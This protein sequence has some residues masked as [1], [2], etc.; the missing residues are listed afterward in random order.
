MSFKYDK[1][2]YETDAAYLESLEQKVH[3]PDWFKDYYTAI[4][5]HSQPESRI[6]D[7]GCGTGITTAWLHQKRPNI[8]GVD[9]SSAFIEK[10]RSRGNYF[11][12]MD[13]MRLEYPDSHFDLVCS[14]DALEHVPGLSQA[15]SEMLRV[16]KPGGVMVVQTPN[17][18]TSVISTNYHVTLPNVFRKLR[19]CG[20]D[21]LHPKLRTV[22]QYALDVKFGDQDAYNLI[23]PLWLKSHLR[24]QSCEIL[25]LTTFALYFRPS[26]PV[27]IALTILSSLPI[28]RHCGGRIVLAARK[29]QLVSSSN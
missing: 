4:L 10:A 21:L 14:A 19:F 13:L 29:S 27:R 15:I 6:L 1:T 11:E 20:Q 18:A 3:H 28:V 22:E 9:F 17:L 2:F 24:D 23:S 12:V 26:F 16:L 7:C 8:R 5:K 25:S